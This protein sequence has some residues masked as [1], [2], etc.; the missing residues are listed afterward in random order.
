MKARLLSLLVLFAFASTF[1]QEKKWNVETNYAVV[2][3]A[4]FGGNDNVFELGLKYRLLQNETLNLGL[5]VNGGFFQEDSPLLPGNNGSETN[6]IIQPRVFS[7]FNLPFSKRLT[8]S[9]GIGY[10]Y[11]SGFEN[12]TEPFGGFNL[13]VGLSYDITG[14]WF[15][16]FQYDRVSLSAIDN[17]EAFN[18]FRLGIGFR[19]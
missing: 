7:E 19:F 13:N 2:P 16:Q 10:S 17:S 14:S 5:S 3:A 1:A 18:N 12:R 15:I 11:L 8:P 9:L 6:Y 4:G